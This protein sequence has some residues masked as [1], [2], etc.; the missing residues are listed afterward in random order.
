MYLPA[1]EELVTSSAML[2]WEDAP[3]DQQENARVSLHHFQMVRVF[4]SRCSLSRLNVDTQAPH[5]VSALTLCIPAATWARVLAEY[6]ASLGPQRCPEGRSG[7]HAGR[8]GQGAGW[9]GDSKPGL[10]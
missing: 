3:H 4:L 1:D 9:A 10:N 6:K 2:E 7:R 8:H 5:A